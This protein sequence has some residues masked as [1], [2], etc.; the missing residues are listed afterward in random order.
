M[1]IWMIWARA[2][3][4][5]WLVTAWDDETRGEAFEQWEMELANVCEEYGN[6]NGRVVGTQIN[7]SDINER[8]GPHMIGSHEALKGNA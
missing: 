8:F 3:G 7:M 1:K 4:N 5:T 6:D 2:E